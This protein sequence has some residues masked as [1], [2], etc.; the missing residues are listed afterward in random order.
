MEGFE[1]RRKDLP[2]VSVLYL[3]GYL[4]AHTAP[5]F[6][7]ALQKLV[8]EGR[9]KIIVNLK[10]LSYISSAGLGVFMGFIDGIRKNGGDIKLT[11]L[12]PKVYK[13]FDLLGFPNLYEIYENDMEA[14]ETF[15][16]SRD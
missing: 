6:E 14:L 5:V 9:Y 1:V 13:I 12:N 4:D 10:D 3:E 15:H 2:E 11:H 16:S 7:A 8:D